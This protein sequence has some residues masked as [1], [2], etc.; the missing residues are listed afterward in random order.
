M[1][2]FIASASTDVELV[3]AIAELLRELHHDP[4]RWNRPGELPSGKSVLDALES[5]LQ[6]SD[7]ALCVATPTDVSIQRGV[8]VLV[9]RD[10]VILEYG[11]FAGRLGRTRVGLVVSTGADVAS[12]PTDLLGIN[13]LALRPREKNES[14][15]KYKDEIRPAVRAWVDGVDEDPVRPGELLRLLCQH[16]TDDDAKQYSRLIRNRYLLTLACCGDHDLAQLIAPAW[17][18][19]S[20][21]P[22]GAPGHT[23]PLDRVLKLDDLDQETLSLCASTLLSHAAKMNPDVDQLGIATLAAPRFSQAIQQKLSF[24]TAHSFLEYHVSLEG[25]P[26]LQG[27]PQPGGHVLILYDVVVSGYQVVRCAEAIRRSGAHVNSVC[28]LVHYKARDRDPVR[29]LSANQLT[30]TAVAQ[31]DGA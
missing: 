7:A 16:L 28:S 24:P 12:L 25:V 27:S 8:Q 18:D 6:H 29:L 2:I 19:G 1:R 11:L 4:H 23:T 15:E 26:H 3:T 30:M 20:A 13:R 17:R 14:L 31:I 5:Q 10:N 22:V 21:R 9:P